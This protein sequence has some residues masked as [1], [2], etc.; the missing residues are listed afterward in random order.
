MVSVE[1]VR[2]IDRPIEEV[3]DR[4]VDIDAYPD[5]LPRGGLFLGCA[6]T[7]DGP[8]AVGT[9]YVDRTRLGAVAGEVVE[10]ERPSRVVFR[11]T[12]RLLGRTVMVG[13]PGYTLHPVD[14]HTRVH[15]VAE[16]H[17]HGPF[18]LLQP[19]VQ[20]VAEHERRRTVDALKASL[21]SGPG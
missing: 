6:Q 11:Y 5:W 16:G 4:L 9:G 14:D 13:W 7:T 19:L 3:F 10:L 17:L 1:L 21:E 18:R 12:A 2:E 8:V 15:H 20:K